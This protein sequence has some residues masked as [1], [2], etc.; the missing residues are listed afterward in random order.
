[1]STYPIEIQVEPAYARAVAS[2]WLERIVTTVLLHEAQSPDRG[3]T[4]VVTDDERIQQLNR[5]YRDVDEP[6]DVLSFPA[7]EAAPSEDVAPS[8]PA[9]VTPEETEPYL[10]DVIISYPTAKAQA[11]A[12]GHPVEDEL[13]LLAVHGCLHLL[14]YDH[15]DEQQRTRMWQRQ[16]DILQEIRDTR[17]AEV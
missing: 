17:E 14:G 15:A 7:E 16:D 6:T 2:A 10:G 5:L 4:L 8:G 9:F 13:A 1:M 11:E 12:Q 3:L